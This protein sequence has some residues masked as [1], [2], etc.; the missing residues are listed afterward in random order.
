[1]IL[2]RYWR[3]EASFVTG[4][5]RALGL[6]DVWAREGAMIENRRRVMKRF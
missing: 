6:K 3:V 5:T 1:M 4:I 2:V